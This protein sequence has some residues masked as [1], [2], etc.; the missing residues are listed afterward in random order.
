MA[1]YTYYY[2]FTHTDKNKIKILY[3]SIY[4]GI[5]FLILKHLY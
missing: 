3:I 2:I 4:Y 5:G 1:I